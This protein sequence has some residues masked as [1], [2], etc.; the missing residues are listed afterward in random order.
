[1]LKRSTTNWRDSASALIKIHLSKN[2]VDV[3]KIKLKNVSTATH[4]V[5]NIRECLLFKLSST[6]D[7]CSKRF[8][9]LN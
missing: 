7:N 5:V 6:I 4:I 1:M 3:K 2:I 9:R 8:Y